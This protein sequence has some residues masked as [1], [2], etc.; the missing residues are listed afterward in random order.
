MVFV[1]RNCAIDNF[2]TV[3]NAGSKR[4]NPDGSHDF[5]P[6][7]ALVSLTGQPCPASPKRTLMLVALDKDEVVSS[8][9]LCLILRRL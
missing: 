3:R 4:T 1:E 9:T 5:W 8:R 2:V 7:S 6:F